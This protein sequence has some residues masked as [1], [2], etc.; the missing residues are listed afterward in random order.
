MASALAERDLGAVIRMFRQWT[1]AS[2]TDVGMLV[3]MPQS[4]LSEV[5]R[6]R[7]KVA[8]L[9]LFERIADG[10]GIPRA[11]LG[12]AELPTGTAESD[13]IGSGQRA[14]ATGGRVAAS[15]REWL[16]TR[17]EVNRRRAELTQLVSSLYPP[18]IRLGTTG[19]LAP[20]AWR[21]PVPVDLDAVELGWRRAPAPTVNGQHTETK[22]LR[23][24]TPGGQHHT[25]YHRAVKD[26]DRPRLFENRLCHRLLEVSP[27]GAGRPSLTITAGDMCYFDMIDVGEALAHEVG[28]AAVDASGQVRPERVTWE[29]LPFRRLL[30][31]PFDLTAYPLMLSVSTLTIRRGPAGTT[32]LLLRRDPAKVAIAGG[33]YSVVPTGVFQ[34]AS[35]VPAPDSPDFD[36]WRNVMREYGEELLGNPDHDG[37]G[38]PLDYENSEPFR[39]L[40]AGRRAGAVRVTCLGVGVDALNYVGDVF[41]V[42]VFEAAFFD[43][44]FDGMVH[45]N[46]EGDLMGG[47]A[48]GRPFTFDEVT[49][50]RLLADGGLAPS[51][52]ACLELA[53]DA[54][55]VILP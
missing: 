25:R 4:H 23:P 7:R 2:Q 45:R 11:R 18:S 39:S 46:D 19:I 55:E 24:L 52:A 33:M 21:L 50:H 31:D 6:G 44:L 28:R 51:G 29:A 48:D 16:R 13:G 34:P 1:G 26:L 9:D 35:V 32:F 3:G 40:D 36:L 10:L 42:A 47:A 53:W 14:D 22:D 38:P 37:D 12:L 17:R 43:R 27:G 54:R 41:T 30:R 5:E 15:R 8:A 49:V 20:P